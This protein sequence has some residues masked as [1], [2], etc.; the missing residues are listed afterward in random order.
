MWQVD[1]EH[2][3]EKNYKILISAIARNIIVLFGV[4]FFKWNI[5]IILVYFWLDCLGAYLLTLVKIKKAGLWQKQRNLNKILISFL[6]IGGALL[7]VMIWSLFRFTGYDLSYL[8]KLN[9]FSVLTVI[10]ISVYD[11]INYYFNVFIKKELFK[12]ITTR[13]Q[14][15][16]FYL[17]SLVICVITFFLYLLFVFKIIITAYIFMAGLFVLLKIITDVFIIT[18]NQNIGCRDTINRIS[19]D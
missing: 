16:E 4:L 1:I 6:L 17:K 15:F 19:T 11:Q 12:N 8:A 7:C 2:W 10:I 9:L 14:S 13:R 18:K 5:F 3:L